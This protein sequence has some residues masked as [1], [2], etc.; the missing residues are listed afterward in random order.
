MEIEYFASTKKG[1]RNLINQ[2]RVLVNDVL[3]AGGKVHG[4]TK[5]SLCAIVC[6]GAGGETR[7]EWGSELA[8]N[9]F[10][11]INL[12][13]ESPSSIYQHLGTI[14]EK[15]IKISN[16]LFQT[17]SR[18]VTTIAGIMISGNQILLF[19][20]GDTRI[21]SI[22]NGE[23]SQLSIDHSETETGN[24]K[25]RLLTKSIGGGDHTW[26][27]TVEFGKIKNDQGLL[28]ICTDGLY[29]RIEKEPSLDKEP[30]ESF[31]EIVRK[32]T[33][34]QNEGT[35]DDASFCILKFKNTKDFS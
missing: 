4:I 16:E 19:N 30:T 18:I 24:K 26:I 17:N 23:L 5:K 29:E 14:N 15:L 21:Y 1:Q 25:Q 28:L 33:S 10:L 9:E 2:D 34:I 32:L 22:V 11:N 3:L 8:A 20:T 27:P 12:I 31:K 13:G 7:G 35:I 6:D